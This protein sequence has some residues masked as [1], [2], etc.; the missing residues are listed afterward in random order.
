MDLEA[1]RTD[2][3]VF[4]SF[5]GPD[6]RQGFA[7]VLYDYMTS[8]GIRVFR[9]DDELAI[10]DKIETII[11]AIDS[12]LICVPIL[13]NTFAASRWCLT[14]V[15][16]M[17]DQ[18]KDVVPIF[19]NVTPDD[20]DLKTPVYREFMAKHE[21]LHG[22]DMAEDWKSALKAVTKLKG[23]ELL[24]NRYVSFSLSVLLTEPYLRQQLNQARELFKTQG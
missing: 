16:R 3:E 1:P 21:R 10:G 15:R 9:D 4:L 11:R 8:A 6:T 20:V 19:Y 7:D 22:K 23:R 18:N 13:S 5:R 24:K 12:S 14:E 2:Y 17:V